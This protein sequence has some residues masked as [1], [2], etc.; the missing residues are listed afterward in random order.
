LVAPPPLPGIFHTLAPVLSNYGYL[1]VAGFVAA[2]DFGIPLPGETVLISA[3]IYAGAGRLNVFAVALTAVVAAVAGDSVGYAIGKFGGR[4]LVARYGRYVFLTPARMAHAEA[5]FTR[6][7]TKV[8]TVARFIEGLRQLNG[9]LA[10]I[11]GMPWRRRFLPFNALGAALW[12]ATWTAVGY[13]AG[14]H[15]VSIYHAVT[16]YSLYALGAAVLLVAVY[17]ALHLRRRARRRRERAADS[18]G[19]GGALGF[20]PALAEV[21]DGLG[22][23]PVGPA[24]EA[25]EGRNEDPP[26][27]GGVDE[28]GQAGAEPEEL[29]EAHLGED[30]GEEA[31]RE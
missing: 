22:G 1:A 30:E 17:V 12:V 16:T 21:A 7:G 25:H 5:V 29:D 31:H 13:F 24:G 9:I 4:A 2:E 23:P 3:A 27:Q 6:Y 15:I 26:H 14:S 28:D 10:G 18:A 19:E 8:V 20:P 11:T